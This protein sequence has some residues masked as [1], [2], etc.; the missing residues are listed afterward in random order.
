MSSTIRYFLLG[1]LA[2]LPILGACSS[3]G[4]SSDNSQARLQVQLTDAT[5]D[6]VQ[7][8]EVW[9]SHV[10]LQGGPGHTADTTDVSTSGRVDLFNNTAAPFHVDLLTLSAGAIKNLTDSITI[11]P[12]TYSQLRIVVDSSKVTLKA[13][14][15]FTDGTST[16]SIKIPSGSTSGIK[17]KLQS[18]VNAAAGT[19]TTLLAD[20]NVEQSFNVQ[21][22][23]NA[24]NVVQSVSLSPVIMEK[25]RS[26]H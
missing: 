19:T 18:N 5:A 3:D 22:K 26:T 25:T 15:K 8:A 20:F 11:D 13:P 24:T 14:W 9:I 1:S 23:P 12:G 7:S 2:L 17:V 16:Q 21:L 4:T 6:Y 10:Y